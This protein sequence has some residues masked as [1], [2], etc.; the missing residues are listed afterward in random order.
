MTRRLHFLD[1]YVRTP[2]TQAEYL[3]AVGGATNLIDLV[4]AVRG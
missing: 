2:S 3:D 4:A 1:R